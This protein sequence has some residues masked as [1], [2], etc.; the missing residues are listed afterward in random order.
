MVMLQK[1]PEAIVEPLKSTRFQDLRYAPYLRK[2]TVDEFIS[3]YVLQAF[4]CYARDT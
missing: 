3:N 1:A 2:I 4:T